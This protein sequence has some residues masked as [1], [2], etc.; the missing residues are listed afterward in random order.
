MLDVKARSSAVRLPSTSEP[1]A[2]G[3][4]AFAFPGMETHMPQRRCYYRMAMGMDEPKTASIYALAD[5]DTGAMRYVG[6]T[7]LDP[8]KRL[9]LHM[10]SARKGNATPNATWI[11]SLLDRGKRPRLIVLET[12]AYGDWPEAE[13]R[14]TRQL[15]CDGADLLNVKSAGGG[16]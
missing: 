1:T 16:R 7:H 12:V 4:R 5:P 10:T 9:D 14:W 3:E 2:V 15:R 11:R 8:R 6:K 13:R